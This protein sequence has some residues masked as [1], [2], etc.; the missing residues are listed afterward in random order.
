MEILIHIRN[1]RTD[2]ARKAGGSDQ[3]FSSNH[4][5]DLIEYRT[6]AQAAAAPHPDRVRRELGL[7]RVTGATAEDLEAL[8]PDPD[9]PLVRPKSIDLAMLESLLSPPDQAKFMLMQNPMVNLP[10]NQVL[11]IPWATVASCLKTMAELQDQLDLGS[12]YQKHPAPQAVAASL[13]PDRLKNA[14]FASRMSAGVAMVQSIQA[15]EGPSGSPGQGQAFAI[16]RPPP[17]GPPRHQF[18]DRLAHGIDDA[19]DGDDAWV[20]TYTSLLGSDG[21]VMHDEVRLAPG[22]SP[23]G[24]VSLR[25]SVHEGPEDRRYPQGWYLVPEGA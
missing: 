8:L 13:L 14:T 1:R 2:S 20:E 6:D 5:G 4:R 10:A 11:T 23:L 12:A 15:G 25:Y 3:H 16:G 7:M 17:P 9:F 24:E 18:P 19:W 21:W 22:E